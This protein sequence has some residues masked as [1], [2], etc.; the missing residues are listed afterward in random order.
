MAHLG[1]SAK[2]TLEYLYS[3]KHFFKNPIVYRELAIVLNQDL[4]NLHKRLSKLET[5]GFVKNFSRPVSETKKT[6]VRHSYLT[7]K[8]KKLFQVK[9]KAKAMKDLNFLIV[10]EP[11]PQESLSDRQTDNKIINE[12]TKKIADESIIK[13]AD[14]ET[15]IKQLTED[16]QTLIAKNI[17]HEQNLS[18][19]SENHSQTIFEKQ[20]ENNDL[21]N[22]LQL[23]QAKLKTTIKNMENLNIALQQS[24][25]SKEELQTSYNNLLVRF[26]EISSTVFEF[27]TIFDIEKFLMD[28]KENHE[29]Y[30]SMLDRITGKKRDRATIM[31]FLDILRE[32]HKTSTA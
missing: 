15:K 9:K 13:I 24:N 6:K 2:Q 4:G 32:F 18:V 19:D 21:T 29:I 12:A 28:N 3:N 16:N 23:N 26:N 20:K 11:K 25:N 27:P 17:K 5:K 30:Q 31:K 10:E 1:K 8:G 14:L 7:E 22:K